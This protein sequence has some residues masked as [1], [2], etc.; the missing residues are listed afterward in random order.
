MEEAEYRELIK[1]VQDLMGRVDALRDFIQTEHLDWARSLGDQFLELFD[2]HVT[3]LS[4]QR[5]H[6]PA[7]FWRSYSYVH[8]VLQQIP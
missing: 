8:A 7:E 6:V 1:V 2:R 5:I 3:M 4:K